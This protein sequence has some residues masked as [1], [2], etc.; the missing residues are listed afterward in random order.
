[1][2]ALAPRARDTLGLGLALALTVGAV[3]AGYVAG[4]A[5]ADGFLAHSAAELISEA[6]IAAAHAA[7][8]RMEGLLLLLLGRGGLR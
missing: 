5:S 6:D 8:A 4:K 7:E 3:G 1:M 2:R